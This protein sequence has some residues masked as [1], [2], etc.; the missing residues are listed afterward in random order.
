[1]PLTT[2]FWCNGGGGGTF[3]FMSTSLKLVCLLKAVKG[4][5]TNASNKYLSWVTIDIQCCACIAWLGGN[6]GSYLIAKT[7]RFFLQLSAYKLCI[8]VWLEQAKHIFTESTPRRIQFISC[9][10]RCVFVCRSVPFKSLFS[11]VLLFPFSKVLGP[12]NLL[13]KDCLDKS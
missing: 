3:D 10:V 2:L 13:Q 5:C 12:K 9:D 6:L 1:M 4:G 8:G 7:G 11:I